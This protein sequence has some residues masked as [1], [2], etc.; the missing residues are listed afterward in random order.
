MQHNTRSVISELLSVAWTTSQ[1]VPVRLIIDACEIFDFSK[2]SVRVS[3]VKMRSE[4][5]VEAPERGLYRLGPAARPVTE[6]VLSWRSVGDRTVA[7]DGSWA[8]AVTGHLTRTDRSALRRRTR[9]FRLLGFRE[10]ETGL[11]VRP[12]NLRGGIRGLRD[13]LIGLGMEQE[14]VVGRLDQLSER[15]RKRALGLWDREAILDKYAELTAELDRS[16]EQ[17]PKISQREA[18]REAYLLGRE[19]LRTIA[20]DPLLPEELLPTAPRQELIET[21][22]RYNETGTALWRRYLGVE[23]VQEV[24]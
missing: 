6:R 23:S 1:P 9:A 8:S 14:A 7:W 13:Q 17:R 10:L 20:L 22:V 24:A 12:N 18:L 19:V 16:T 3:L 5:L 4:G 2:N 11:F 21:M 15:D